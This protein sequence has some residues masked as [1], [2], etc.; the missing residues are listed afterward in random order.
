MFTAALPGALNVASQ[1][2]RFFPVRPGNFPI[3]EEEIRGWRTTGIGSEGFDPQRRFA[4]PKGRFREIR[5]SFPAIR[6]LTSACH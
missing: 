4:S 6:E 5:D 1:P 3:K 2:F